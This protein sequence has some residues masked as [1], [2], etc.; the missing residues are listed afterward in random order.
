MRHKIAFILFYLLAGCVN[1]TNAQDR[2]VVI[3]SQLNE[4][5]KL[6]PGLKEKIEISV[7]DVSVQDFLRGIADANNLNISVDQGINVKV[8]SNF[9]DVTVIDVLIFLCKKYELDVKFIGAIINLAPY[10]PPPI[11]IEEYVQKPILLNYNK[12]SDQ[13]SFDLNND[14]LSLVT[15]ELTKQSG[16]NFVYLPELGSKLL[17]GFVQDLDFDVALQKMAFSNNISVS[18]SDCLSNNSKRWLI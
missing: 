3:E 16:K 8:S 14:S 2:Y 10:I 13:L 9:K 7:N 5:V 17:N 12:L 4:L 11:P 18:F 1:Y 6:Q 15:K